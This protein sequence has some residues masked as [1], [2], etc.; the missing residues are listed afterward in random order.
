MKNEKELLRKAVLASLKN[1]ERLADSESKSEETQN[2]P[3]DQGLKNSVPKKKKSLSKLR[4]KKKS[5]SSTDSNWKALQ[6]SMSKD[7]SGQK[8]KRSILAIKE[9]REKRRK[10]E[11]D[12]KEDVD[13][14]YSSFMSRA[15]Q[16]TSDI[17]DAVAIDCEMVGVGSDGKESALARVSVVNY[18]GDVLY[19]KF[20]KVR[21]TITDYRTQWSGIRPED[22][23]LD[24]TKAVEEYE[25]QE[26]VGE[27]IRGRILIGHAL[28]NDLRVLRIAHPWRDVRDTSE[29]YKKLWRKKG[30]RS[31]KPPALREIV[32][33]VLGVDAF[34]KSEHDSCEDARAALAL[35][36]RNSKQWEAELRRAGL[37]S[38]KKKKKTHNIKSND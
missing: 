36:K 7:N 30:R 35:Y 10:L 11:N 38:D 29:F 33:K 2:L 28:K 14:R 12:G 23:A 17:T 9:K 27:V 13:R 25:A 5:S 24:S 1:E 20:I 18:T 3:T 6:Q 34:Q 4:T 31:A 16:D 8:R 22:V 15:V 21:E 37:T 32:A 19:D 26:A